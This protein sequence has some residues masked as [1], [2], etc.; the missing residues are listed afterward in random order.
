MNKVLL[1][2]E[3]HGSG[4]VNR[5]VG[6]CL[7]RDDVVFVLEVALPQWPLD[8]TPCTCV[9]ACACVRVRAVVSVRVRARVSGQ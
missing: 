5:H 6:T 7:P 1:V 2:E 4:D 9:R 3:G 8:A